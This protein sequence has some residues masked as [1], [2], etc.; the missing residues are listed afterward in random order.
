MAF[1]RGELSPKE[2]NDVDDEAEVESEFMGTFRKEGL[3]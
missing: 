1:R 2:L 3:I